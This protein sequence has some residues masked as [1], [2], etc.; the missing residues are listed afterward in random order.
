MNEKYIE[1]VFCREVKSLGGLALKL[2][3]VSV[4]GLPDRLVL[5]PGGVSFFV[6]LKAPGG[7]CT[8]LQ[9]RTHEKLKKLGFIVYVCDSLGMINQIIKEY[10]S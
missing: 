4:A 8:L 2:W 6:E 5:L 10:V 3:P 9:R 1:K 7:R